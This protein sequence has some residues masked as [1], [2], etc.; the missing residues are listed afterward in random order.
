MR[1]SKIVRI[2]EV[3]L[4]CFSSELELEIY[5][6]QVCFLFFSFVIYIVLWTGS[7]FPFQNSYFEILTPNVTVLGG[8]AFGGD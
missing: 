3:F 4:T 2:E 6:D 8:G 1:Y 5:I 7:L